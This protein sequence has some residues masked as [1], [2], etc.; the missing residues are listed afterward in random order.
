V[1]GIVPGSDGEWNSVCDA[2]EMCIIA[3]TEAVRSALRRI[4]P[5]THACS[6][7]KCANVKDF[8]CCARSERLREGMGSVSSILAV[9]D[10]GT[11]R[12]DM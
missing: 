5:I 2:S 1:S 9:D 7:V 11:G 8:S 6:H 4:F 10:V 3:D 12:G